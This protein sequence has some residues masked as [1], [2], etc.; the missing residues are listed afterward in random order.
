MGMW[1]RGTVTTGARF[2]VL[3]VGESEWSSVWPGMFPDVYLHAFALFHLISFYSAP[4]FLNRSSFLPSHGF[5]INFHLRK[6]E[7]AAE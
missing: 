1:T 6:D 3:S 4:L 2:L 7:V 5:G